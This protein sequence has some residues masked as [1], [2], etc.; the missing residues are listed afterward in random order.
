MTRKVNGASRLRIEPVLDTPCPS[1]GDV[2]GRFPIEVRFYQAA[3]FDVV[4]CRGCYSKRRQDF[5]SSD[6]TSRSLAHLRPYADEWNAALGRLIGQ[7]STAPDC[8]GIYMLSMNFHS[9]S[10]DRLA[11][12]IGQS[13]SSVRGRLAVH[14]ERLGR[15]LLG[16]LDL[17]DFEALVDRSKLDLGLLHPGEFV[18]IF[19][20]YA[21]FLD[22]IG[23]FPEHQVLRGSKNPATRSRLPSRLSTFVTD[24]GCDFD[25]T[26]LQTFVDCDSAEMSAYRKLRARISHLIEMHPDEVAILRA[27]RAWQEHY[28]RM[29][30][31]P[32]WTVQSRF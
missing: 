11:A 18:S 7:I 19:G 12:Y 3:G 9:L 6:N 1:C 26:I 29:G 25:L 13:T 4:L 21:T 31:E 15:A 14:A 32:L 2:L 24:H 17:S 23:Y 8:A 27:E 20:D 28:E 16:P 5:M 30:V 10:G 22:T